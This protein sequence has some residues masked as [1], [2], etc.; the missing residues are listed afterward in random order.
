M[1]PCI[2]CL[3]AKLMVCY[4]PVHKEKYRTMY[5][6]ENSLNESSGFPGKKKTIFKQ[7][8]KTS[9][10]KRYKSRAEL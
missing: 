7:L 2:K 4:F 1:F 10:G 3:P 5:T 6:L 8:Q 9:Y